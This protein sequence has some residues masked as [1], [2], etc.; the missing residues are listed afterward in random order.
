L[1]WT[2]SWIIY[3]LRSVKALT[4]RTVSAIHTH[5]DQDH[6]ELKPAQ[7]DKEPKEPNE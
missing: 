6:G 1:D 7:P 5:K 2:L 4:Q 3:E